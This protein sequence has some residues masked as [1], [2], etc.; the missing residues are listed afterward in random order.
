MLE[1]ID[2]YVWFQNVHQP[3]YNFPYPL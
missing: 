3:N 2:S 1:V